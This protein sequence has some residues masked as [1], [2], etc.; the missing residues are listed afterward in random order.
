MMLPRLPR[1]AGTKASIRATLSEIRPRSKDALDAYDRRTVWFWLVVSFLYLGTTIISLLGFVPYRPW[2]FAFDILMS[3][4]FAID[5]GLRFY[6][7]EQRLRFVLRL[8]NLADIV[9]ILTPFLAVRFGDTW[10]GVL[11]GVRIIR[12]LEI[13]WRRSG[14]V[15]RRGQVRL[16]AEG[17][18]AVVVLS[19][20]IVWASERTHPDSP[21]HSLLDAGWWAIVTMFTVGYGD[22]YPHTLVGK[23][24]AVVVMFCGIALFGWLTAALASLFVENDESAADQEMNRKLDEITAELAALKVLLTSR[25]SEQAD[26]GEIKIGVG[27]GPEHH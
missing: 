11:R 15:L 19:V 13:L 6:M 10:A 3:F 14:K 9:V 16:V 26:D 25:A 17:A 12:L 23:L 1:W 2:L 20:L 22:A 4:V 21:I 24:G 18:L 8:W 7:A 27:S 5:Y